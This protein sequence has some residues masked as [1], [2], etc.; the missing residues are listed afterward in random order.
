MRIGKAKI[1]AF[2]VLSVVFT[3]LVIIGVKVIYMENGTMNIV[4]DTEKKYQTFS[5]F[6][7]SSCWW[8]QNISDEKTRDEIAKL[9]FS[10][11]G[12]GL[13]I[14]R[15]NVGGG[16]NPEHNRVTEP[17]RNTE[18]FYYFDDK[19]GEWKYD[20][21]RDKNAQDF[22]FKSLSYGCIDTVV[23]F[24]NSPH[25]SMT[26]TGEA[27]GGAEKGVTNIAPD[28]YAPFADYFLDITEYFISKGV[29]VKYISPI[30]EPQWDWGGDDV[31]QEGCHYEPEEAL[32]V[33]EVFAKKIQERGLDV[34]LSLP[35]SGEIGESTM[36]YFTKAA[37]NEVT[38]RNTG[39][40]AYH[41]Y[42]SD[43]NPAAK[44]KFGSWYREQS[45][46]DIP[47]DMTEWC[48]L[49]NKHDTMS[50]EGAALMARIV[51]ND[52]SLTGVNSWTAW[53]GV[54]RKW[55]QEDGLDYTDAMITANDDFS[56]WSITMRY[57][58]MAHF[59]KFIPKG[60]AAVDAQSRIMPFRISNK[61]ILYKTNFCAFLTPDGKTVLVISNEDKEK[62][63]SLTAE[64]ENMEV[65]T[66]D[67]LHK[68]EKTFSGG[69]QSELLLP[70]N[71]I[72]TVV[73]D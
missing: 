64:G 12:L 41:S 7:T 72:T 2:I 61:K 34:K 4:I 66:T 54:N 8:S 46:S 68:L 29:P 40:F 56:E 5:G 51:A 55:I 13:K 15:Y 37:E 67:D 59:S 3:V 70:E 71:S 21:T 65:Y 11:E 47:L 24:A 28:M 6:G 27:S 10:E 30:N 19:A 1:P 38:F 16:V 50:A 53:V 26:V 45:F 48:E 39:S 23:L 57:Y 33:F 49:P 69:M 36:E 9:L 31:N 17:W 62:T 52:L 14:F 60:S 43:F 18:S 44:K 22:L 20:F 35:D 73:I 42:W 25:Y 58:A 32:K 63:V